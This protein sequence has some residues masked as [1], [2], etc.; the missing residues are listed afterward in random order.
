MKKTNGNPSPSPENPDIIGD[1]GDYIIFQPAFAQ[2]VLK[3]FNEQENEKSKKTLLEIVNEEA[4]SNPPGQDDLIS[5]L[6]LRYHNKDSILTSEP[7]RTVLKKYK[8]SNDNG[9]ITTMGYEILKVMNGLSPLS[10]LAS[11]TEDI[12]LPESPDNETDPNSDPNMDDIDPSSLMAAASSLKAAVQKAAQQEENNKRCNDLWPRESSEPFS[13]QESRL[14]R[15][16]QTR[17]NDQSLEET[18][19]AIY[20][21]NKSKHKFE[22]YTNPDDQSIIVKTLLEPYH[23][24]QA[25]FLAA[26]KVYVNR[27]NHNRDPSDPIVYRRASPFGKDVQGVISFCMQNQLP[28]PIIK[29]DMRQEEKIMLEACQ[30]LHDNDYNLNLALD[31]L[32]N[33]SNSDLTHARF[34]AWGFRQDSIGKDQLNKIRQAMIEHSKLT[35]SDLTLNI[36]DA[37]TRKQIDALIIKNESK[38]IQADYQ[39]FAN[40]TPGSPQQKER[41]TNIQTIPPMPK[42]HQ[43]ALTNRQLQSHIDTLKYNILAIS[44]EHPD[45]GSPQF[46]EDDLE[47]FRRDSNAILQNFRQAIPPSP[48]LADAET[49]NDSHEATPAMNDESQALADKI[50]QLPHSKSGSTL[51]TLFQNL[52]SAQTRLSDNRTELSKLDKQ[53]D[54][55]SDNRSPSLQR[56]L[57]SNLNYSGGAGGMKR[58]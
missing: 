56:Q 8:P 20:E 22:T 49:H 30:I 40:T 32:D 57:S 2:A 43:I 48:I 14:Y 27:L 23:T 21:P 9:A 53:H 41:P 17:F 29:S 16:F 28:P 38:A 55:T 34:T 26:A 18:L 5:A 47:I 3:Y 42:Q 4:Q 6:S 45:Q 13:D 24:Q 58:T 19:F 36:I 15:S 50:K 25:G 10:A 44:N 35:D 52:H 1:I 46:T 31:K 51:R 54:S 11:D 33:M 37:R 7:I 39:T 12:Q